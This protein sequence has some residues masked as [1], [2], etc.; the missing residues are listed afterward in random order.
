MK[1]YFI[2]YAN[3]FK[4]E[5]I[6]IIKEL[7]EQFYNNYKEACSRKI[8]SSDYYNNKLDLN[9]RVFSGISYI[10]VSC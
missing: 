1:S 7:L 4:S 9:I 6:H 10:I 8:T 3:V 5:N 2:C